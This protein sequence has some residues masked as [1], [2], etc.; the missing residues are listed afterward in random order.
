MFLGVI[1]AKRLEVFKIDIS[2]N[3]KHLKTGKIMKIDKKAPGTVVIMVLLGA[4]GKEWKRVC[5]KVNEIKKA[6]R[7]SA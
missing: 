2:V 7:L 4:A 5:G 1:Y 3:L 6:K